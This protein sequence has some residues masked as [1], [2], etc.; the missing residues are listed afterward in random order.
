MGLPRDCST[1]DIK[2]AYKKLALQWHPDRNYGQEELA[3]KTFK[4]ISASYNVLSD[5]QERQWY[6]D[7]REA[8]LRGKDFRGE[9]EEGEDDIM[10]NLFN[11]F[12]TSCFSDFNDDE[13]GF[14]DVY[15]DVFEEILDAEEE[16][17]N[18]R[19]DLPEFGDSE[20]S[21]SEVY[22]FYNFWENFVTSASFAWH[23]K[24]NVLDAPNRQVKRAMEKENSKFRD[25]ARKEYLSNVKQ[26]VAFVKKRDP[27]Y[28][29]FEEV[30]RQRKA[31]DAAKKLEAK[32]LEA[33][34]KK[35]DREKWRQAAEE[36]RGLR[37]KE[38]E[39]AFLLADN[40]SDLEEEDAMHHL[41]SAADLPTEADIETVFSLQGASLK[42]PGASASIT[43]DGTEDVQTEGGDDGDDGNGGSFNCEVCAKSYK[44]AMQLSQ[45]LQSK[46]HRK[47]V[48]E[49]EKASKK[50]GGSSGKSKK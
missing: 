29:A 35:A 16:H 1:E 22:E 19:P 40:D 49:V 48:Q 13:G 28:A 32:K 46:N 2:K 12:T 20:S 33:E 41:A 34:R 36:E 15:G 24:Y 39:R 50:K 11:Y 3:S 37:E 6:D 9:G 27:R 5:S 21:E 31:E 45:H 42:E 14:Y 10:P 43:E 38:R 26:L 7:H 18:S 8:I 25:T 47:K 17:G 44:T 30:K 23:D 4:E